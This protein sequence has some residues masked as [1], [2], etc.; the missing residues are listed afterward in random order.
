[1]LIPDKNVVVEAINMKYECVLSNV[2]RKKIM[3]HGLRMEEVN[4]LDTGIY[5]TS[6]GTRS[7]RFN[8]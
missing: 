2:I 1:M 6:S 8:D 4:A 3:Y 5:I 7:V